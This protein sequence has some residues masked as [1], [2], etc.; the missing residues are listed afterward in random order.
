MQLRTPDNW[1]ATVTNSNAVFVTKIAAVLCNNLSRTM[2]YCICYCSLHVLPQ[3]VQYSL[4]ACHFLS[5]VSASCWVRERHA[6]PEF[7]THA[8]NPQYDAQNPQLKIH[9][10]SSAFLFYSS[11]HDT[12]CLLQVMP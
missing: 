1:S 9:L 2:Q 11:G 12:A 3:D 7:H 5:S 10:R 4:T 6:R 8:Q